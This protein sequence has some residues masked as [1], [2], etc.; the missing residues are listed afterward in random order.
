VVLIRD[1]IIFVPQDDEKPSHKRPVKPRKPKGE[2]TPIQSR[3][4]WP[5]GRKLQSRNTLKR[6]R[7]DA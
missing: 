7:T 5:S 3:N 2:R 4:D 6:E 1:G